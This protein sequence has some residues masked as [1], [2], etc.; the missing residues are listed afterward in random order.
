MVLV[1]YKPRPVPSVF[2]F[3]TFD[4]Y[5]PLEVF[6]NLVSKVS[7]DPKYVCV[8]NDDGF[9]VF[10]ARDLIQKAIKSFPDREYR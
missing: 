8:F 10:Y 7:H 3:K 5:D 2:D 6:E 1:M 9:L 4:G